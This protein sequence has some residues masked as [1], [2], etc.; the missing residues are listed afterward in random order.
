MVEGER[1]REHAPHGG[2]SRMRHY[3]GSNPP[4]A[5][6]RNLG[7]NDHQVRKEAPDHAEVRKRYGRAAK[8]LRRNRSRR[9]VGPHAV[10]PRA[11]ILGIALADIAQD[12]HEQ[13][14]FEIHRN[15][16]VDAGDEAP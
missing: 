7:R 4:G 14:A 12:R 5:H 15:P 16:D 2:L 9:S 3:A 8:L 11:Q 13:P 1:E 6:D 10:K